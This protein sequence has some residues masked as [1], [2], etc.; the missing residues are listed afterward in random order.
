[1]MVSFN[2]K[3]KYCSESKDKTPSENTLAPESTTFT[4]ED[5][6]KRT[7]EE[8]EDQELVQKCHI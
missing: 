2:L 3:S 7:D 8:S 1:M 6:P 5:V 4:P